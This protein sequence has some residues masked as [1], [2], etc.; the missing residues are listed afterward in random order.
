MKRITAAKRIKTHLADYRKRLA[1]DSEASLNEYSSS[2]PQRCPLCAACGAREDAQHDCDQCLTWPTT[3]A[4][5]KDNCF[6]FMGEVNLLVVEENKLALIDKLE[7]EL[8]RWAAEAR[9]E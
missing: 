2:H 9:H 7:V 8:A 5:D 3:G 1:V 6:T 4:L